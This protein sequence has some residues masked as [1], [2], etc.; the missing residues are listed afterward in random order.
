MPAYRFLYEKRPIASEPSADALKLTGR[1]APPAG[2]EIVPTYDAQCLVAY[3]MSLDQSHPLKEVK[4]PAVAPAA[5]PAAAPPASPAASP[6]AG[7]GTK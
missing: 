2:W 5:S 1:D 7:K 3:L 4:S 6:A